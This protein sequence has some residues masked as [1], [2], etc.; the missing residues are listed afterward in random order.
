MRRRRGKEGI[1]ATS[2]VGAFKTPF[3]MKGAT[4]KK[5][6]MAP[7]FTAKGKMDPMPKAGGKMKKMPKMAGKKR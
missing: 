2:P 5:G 3:G 4:M 6:K 1:S 7:P